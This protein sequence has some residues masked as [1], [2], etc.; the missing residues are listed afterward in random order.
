M[1]EEIPEEL[2]GIQARR[3]LWREYGVQISDW[4]FEEIISAI[5]L[6]SAI[7]RRHDAIRERA[8]HG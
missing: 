1:T 5:E 2:S 4:T 8:Q 3:V 6:D 7:S